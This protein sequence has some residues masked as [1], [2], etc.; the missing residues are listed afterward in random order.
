VK[1][2]TCDEQLGGSLKKTAM[3]SGIAKALGTFDA[4]SSYQ[5]LILIVNRRY[6]NSLLDRPLVLL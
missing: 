5:L 3:V 4:L 6:L 1:H 2:M